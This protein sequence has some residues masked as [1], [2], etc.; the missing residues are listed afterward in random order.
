MGKIWLQT[1]PT[2]L[3]P[4]SV[5]IHLPVQG[6]DVNSPDRAILIPTSII[7]NQ[8]RCYGQPIAISG[9]YG[10]FVID[11]RPDGITGSCNQCGMCCGHPVAD[12][13]HG[14]DC[15]YIL[16]SD[17]N[18]HVCQYLV[19]DKWRKWGDPDNSHCSLYASILDEF[20]GCAYPPKEI[21][22]WMTG[23]GYS[24]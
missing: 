19:I 17:L 16:H 10:D 3:H 5:L 2:A 23:C 8:N 22:S 21:K 15:G 9:P 11:L 24:F 1:T 7:I 13:T 4:Q 18:W 14:E 6:N 20:K 12:C